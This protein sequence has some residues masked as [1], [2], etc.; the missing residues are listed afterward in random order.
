MGIDTQD[1]NGESDEEGEVDL[2]AELISVLEELEKC[3][4]KNRQSNHVISELE[5]QLLEAKKIE[6]DLNLQLKR[7]IQDS[8]R[9]EEEIMQVRKRLDE[10][11]IKSKFENNSKVLDDILSSQRPSSNN[12]SL[13]Y[14]KAKKPEYSSFTDQ[15]GNKIIYA[16]VLKSPM[17]KQESKKSGPSSYDKKNKNK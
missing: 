8:K 5:T 9:F 6:E 10:E 3:K 11:A 16:Y 14:D 2:K 12:S 1:Q 17:K 7:R 4:R 13:G 15:G